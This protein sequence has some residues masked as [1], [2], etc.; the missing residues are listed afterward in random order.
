VVDQ[1]AR[2]LLGR[3]EL[4]GSSSNPNLQLMRMSH[5]MLKATEQLVERQALWQQ[6]I[7]VAPISG[8]AVPSSLPIKCK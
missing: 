3:F 8:S 2:R 6:S 5:A 7:S 4:V 1:R